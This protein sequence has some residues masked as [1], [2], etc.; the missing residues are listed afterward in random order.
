MGMYMVRK[1]FFPDRSAN[2]TA[3][4]KTKPFPFFA[5]AETKSFG[6]FFGKPAGRETLTWY[7]PALIGEYAVLTGETAHS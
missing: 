2:V 4:L 6:V 1:F 3:L 5:I 7:L